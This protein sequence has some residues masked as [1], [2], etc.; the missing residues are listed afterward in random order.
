MEIYAL[1]CMLWDLSVKQLK[2]KYASSLLGIFW[3]LLNPLLIVAAVV[4]VFNAVFKIEIA[5]FPFF[6]LSG[7]FPWMFFSA[8]LNEAT[9]SIINQQNILRQFN[10]PSAIVPLSSVL[11]NFLNFLLGLSIIYPLFYLINPNIILLLP[12]LVLVLLL[13][14][15][16]T[17]GLGMLLAASNVFFRDVSRVLEVILMFWFWVT[18]VFYSVEMVPAKL[19]W[20][21]NINP[22]TPFI[23]GFRKLIFDGRL[24]EAGV[25]AGVLLWAL[26]SVVTGGFVF[27]RLEPKLL[28]RL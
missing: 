9:S 23:L 24:P 2:A 25:W 27:S 5:N 4:F 21:S 7:I 28:K 6:A 22:M 13:N 20:V 15:I 11:S 12:F 3:A 1:R 18:P 8:A 17:F 10:L 19:C 14:L 26:I 16:F